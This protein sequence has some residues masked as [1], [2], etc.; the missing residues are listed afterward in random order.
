MLA[1]LACTAVLSAQQGQPGPAGE[2]ASFEVASVKPNTSGSLS[3]GIPFYP[4]GGFNATNVSLKS[5]IAIAYEV[6]TFQVEGGPD[7]AT[8]AR[9]DITARGREGTPDRMRP[10][11]LRSLLADRFKLV[12]RVENRE[13]PMYAL[14]L[15]NSDGRPGP[16]LKPSPPAPESAASNKGGLFTSVRNGTGRVTGSRMSM[17]AIAAALAGVTLNQ[18]VINRTGLN[19]EFDFDLQFTADTPASATDRAPEFPA[20]VTAVQEQLG[21]KLQ[22]ERGPVPFVVIESLQQPTPN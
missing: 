6:R 13:Q 20:L 9:Y 11:M 4:D 8:S 15:A 2:T 3:S 1:V 5:L 19:G 12:V 21:L 18:R 16:N 22:S 7:W 17:D 10:A 14:V